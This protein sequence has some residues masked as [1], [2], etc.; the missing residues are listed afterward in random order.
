[1]FR[2]IYNKIEIELDIIP[3][4]PLLIKSGG[5]SPNP[6][7]P[8]MQFVR[9]KIGGI[10]QMYVPGSSS[11]G[12][13]R[14]YIEK[15]L[16]TKLNEKGACDIF[17]NKC[18][19]NLEDEIKKGNVLS[20]EIYKNSCLACRIFGNTYLKSRI[21]ISDAYPRGDIKTEVRYGVAISRLTH[22]VASGPFNIESAVSGEFNLKINLENF[23]LWQL[24]TIALAIK[25]LNSEMI[26]IGYGKNRGFG[27]VLA[28]IKKIK[29]IFTSAITKNQIWGVGKF[30]NADVREN[31][32]LIDND[33]IEIT[34]T[35]I[36]E[37]DEIIYKI[38]EYSHQSWEEISNKV[39]EKFKQ[40]ME[41]V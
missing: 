4:S 12:I 28:D 7:L 30:V 22:A 24:G 39:I 9:T 23:E 26:K 13:F 36:N 1:M 14:S 37:A 11:K 27:A 2:E 15:I 3:K 16:R 20:Y 19:R 29:F 35:P 25:G 17:N 33:Q 5:I 34:E 32:D 8:D 38:V 41:E 18:L 31:Y 21:L 10:E 6:S 40:K